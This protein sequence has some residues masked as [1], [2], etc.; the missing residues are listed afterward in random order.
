MN[1]FYKNIFNNYNN[2][3]YFYTHYSIK[4]GEYKINSEMAKL[5]ATC[6]FKLLSQSEKL[7]G[8][9]YLNLNNQPVKDKDIVEF[10][11]DKDIDY[12]NYGKSTGG[13]FFRI[14]SSDQLK[15]YI[16]LLWYIDNLQ[17]FTADFELKE[18]V[19]PERKNFIRLGNLRIG[20]NWTYDIDRWLF[21][22]LGKNINSIITVCPWINETMFSITTKLDHSEEY[23]NAVSKISGVILKAK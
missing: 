8:H 12:I 2:I 15:E 22:S 11:H 21:E 6:V 4:E 3:L 20:K 7:F 23:L 14:D 1:I 17:F 5:V 13:L 9:Q 18:L 16:L 19:L 10:M